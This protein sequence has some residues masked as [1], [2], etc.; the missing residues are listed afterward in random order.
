M[1]WSPYRATTQNIRETWEGDAVWK[2]TQRCFC[3]TRVQRDVTS[4]GTPNKCMHAKYHWVLYTHRAYL[5]CNQ[6][7]CNITRHFRLFNSRCISL[8]TLIFGDS[9]PLRMRVTTQQTFRVEC[10]WQ[11][12]S[13][14][15]PPNLIFLCITCFTWICMH[16]ANKGRW[17]QC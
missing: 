12:I 11:F 15:P 6:V 1:E 14:P 10:S 16:H 5:V 3:P 17:V 7:W 13:P 4:F 8:K 9:P 2:T